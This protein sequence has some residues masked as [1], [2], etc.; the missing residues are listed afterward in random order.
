MPVVSISSDC[1]AGRRKPLGGVASLAAAVLLLLWP[2]WHNGYPLVFSDTGTYLTQIVERHL[3]W[4]RPMFYSLAIL[5][6]HLTL[7][8]WP[9][10]VAQA[11]LTVYLLCVTLRVVVGTVQHLGALT[12]ALSVLTA[13]PWVTSELIP[14]FSTPLLVLVLTLL[15][16]LP[17]RLTR[18]EGWGLA[19]LGAMLMAVHLSNVL[20]A[21]LLLAVLL[22]MRRLLG[23]RRPLARLDLVRAAGPW[24]AAALALGTVNLIGHGRFSLSPY[25]SVFVLTR[26]LYDGPAMDVLRRHCPQAGWR[27]CILVPDGLPASP[28]EFLWRRSSPLQ[29]VGGPKQIAGEAKAILLTALHEEPRAMLWSALSDTFRQLGMVATGD[30]LQPWPETVTPVIHRD[31]PAAEA[32]RYD[33]ALQTTG[34]L[35]VPGWLQALHTAALLLGVAATLASLGAALRRRHPVAGLC[36]ATLVCLLANAAV[37]GAL[38]GPHDR[39]QSRVAWLVVFAPLTAGLA[40]R[41]HNPGVKFNRS[42]DRAPEDVAAHT[43]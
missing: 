31:F 11:V 14:D 1:D 7:T 43:A 5:P 22:P 2:A 3:G 15:V 13:L 28:D 10:V 6:L 16:V 41:Q 8:N 19:L 30:G 26:S 12:A 9:V 24:L 39:Y 4:D 17:D 23:A 33:A 36:A 42:P 34:H 25:G 40:L 18:R 35:A 27:L 32:R 20:L 29:R 38:S 21:P 37:T